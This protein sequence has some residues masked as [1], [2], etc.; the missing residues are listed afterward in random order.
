MLD[1]KESH[2]LLRSPRSPADIHVVDDVSPPDGTLQTV[3]A[4]WARI[5]RVLT[6]PDDLSIVHQPILDVRTGMVAG[7]EALARFVEGGTPDT[8]FADAH[9]FGLGPDLEALAIKRALSDRPPA[10]T[11]LSINLGPTALVSSAVNRILPRRL[12]NVVIEITEHEQISE[13][14]ALTP[15]IDE[16]RGRGAAFG[17]DDA[18]SG[19]AGFQQLMRLE[20]DLIKLDRSLVRGVVHDPVKAALINAIVHFADSIDAAVCAEGVEDIAE[21]AAIAELGVAYAQGWAIAMPGAGWPG[22]SDAAVGACHL[23]LADAL[24]PI[25]FDTQSTERRLASIANAAAGIRSDEDAVATF[26]LIAQE[27]HAEHVCLSAIID[28]RRAVQSVL[29]N[30]DFDGGL[31][32]RLDEHPLTLN[33]I[34]T[35]DMVQVVANDPAADP[36]E[37][38][39]MVPEGFHRLLMAPIVLD[40]TSIALLEICGKSARPWNRAEIYRT[41]VICQLLA[42]SIAR[43]VP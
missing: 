37:L 24:G 23:S 13:I 27:L 31:V 33:V 11:Y 28:D 38:S 25:S 35:G 36:T 19:Y 8:W 43:L 3:D 30:A 14:D 16:L 42:P 6:H 10:G 40:G 15:L 21:L 9:R 2:G 34:E 12:G 18:G 7:Y 20:P 22:P 39:W 32:Y 17:V 26:D 41:R 5:E 1:G 4:P 29:A